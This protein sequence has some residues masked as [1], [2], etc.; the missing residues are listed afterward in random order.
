MP[1]TSL[2]EAQDFNK[3]ESKQEHWAEIQKGYLRTSYPVW[4]LMRV[5]QCSA[6]W[7]MAEGGSVALK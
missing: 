7:V 4:I 6:K 1:Q 2:K 3:D 5:S